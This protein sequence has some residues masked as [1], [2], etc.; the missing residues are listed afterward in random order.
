[1]TVVRPTPLVAALL[2]SLLGTGWLGAVPAAAGPSSDPISGQ[3]GERV[4]PHRDD[5]ARARGSAGRTRAP[6]AVLRHG[7]HDYRYRYRLDI[8]T[9]DWTL[10]TF[11]D[12]R[13]GETVASGAFI[14]ESDPK[15]ARSA[16]RLCR[17]STHTGRFTIRAKLIYY[18]DSGRHR[19]WLKRSHFRLR[20]G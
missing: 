6:D 9:N 11:L 4:G 1:M 15:R 7:C 2:G 13:T 8:R 14:A 19:V 3:V 20:R 17:Y 18:T 12:D 10:E 16:F 5:G